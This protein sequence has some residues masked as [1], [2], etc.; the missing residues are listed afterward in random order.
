MLEITMTRKSG[1]HL[2]ATLYIN[3]S[4]RNYIIIFPD[5]GAYVMRTRNSDLGRRSPAGGRVRCREYVHI[6]KTH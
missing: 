4:I 5:H 1:K 2:H 6:K 3:S